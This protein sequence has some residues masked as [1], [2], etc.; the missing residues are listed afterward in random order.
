M[1][2]HFP[3]H[4]NP[5][6]DSHRKLQFVNRDYEELDS[7]DL[8]PF[9][10]YSDAGLSGIMVGHLAVPSIDSSGLPAA[11]SPTVINELLRKN[12]NFGGLVMTDAMNMGGAEGYSSADAIIA[13]A[14]LIIAPRNTYEDIREIC[15]KVKSGELPQEELKER[16]RRIVFYKN[17]FLNDT[18]AIRMN[19]IREEVSRNSDS[20]R[21]KLRGIGL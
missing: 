3:G 18:S 1:A 14:D 2:K 13:G 11:V 10:K 17:L 15:E 19:R 4:G 5:S 7:I 9:R 21:L 12:L 16:C 20:I 8:Y 6:G